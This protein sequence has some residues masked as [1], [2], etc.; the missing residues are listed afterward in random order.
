MLTAYHPCRVPL[1]WAAQQLGFD[2][3]QQQEAMEYLQSQGVVLDLS[4]MEI[5]TKGTRAAGRTR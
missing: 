4:T 5:D 3:D 2:T 1:S